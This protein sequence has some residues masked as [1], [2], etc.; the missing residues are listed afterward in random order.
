M[1]EV[2]IV[3]PPFTG[4]V[5]PT[6]AVGAAL[7]ERGH[8]VAYFGVDASLR[9][10][11]PR[12]AAFVPLAHGASAAQVLEHQSRASQARR[13]GGLESLLFVYEKVLAPLARTMQPALVEHF[14]QV[15]PD[16][17]FAD[18]QAFAGVFAAYACG[19]PA[20]LSLSVP[21]TLE[22]AGPLPQ[23]ARW[24]R[25]QLMRLQHELTGEAGRPLCESLPTLVYS[26]P[27]FMG[28]EDF[29]G[30]VHFV[31]PALASREGEAE[32]P[33]QEFAATR[34]PRVLVS[35]GTVLSRPD[36]HAKVCEALGGGDLTVVL[37]A[38]HA[39]RKTWPR[40][41]LVAPR[42]PQLALL[43]H[44]DTVLCHGGHN[45]VS[46][47]LFAGLPVVVVPMAFDQFSVANRVTALG[48][49]LRLHASRTSAADLRAAVERAAS[50][51]AMRAAAGTVQASYAA[52]GGARRAALVLESLARVHAFRRVEGLQVPGGA[53]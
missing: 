25:E 5:N 35:V 17:V 43:P 12:G 13:A 23:V 18:Y 21:S 19:I 42:V 31:G 37:V 30:N 14:E 10:R 11:I 6:L 20:A 22:S 33:W 29:P 9:A 47:S 36:F 28:R 34:R 41:F 26:S 52:A 51:G 49:G 3:V 8:R 15:R 44:L 46:E 27:L 24:E 39:S 48:C 50:D 1:A 32:F 2:A 38:E 40:N 4:H 7:I 53:P 45:T 16:I